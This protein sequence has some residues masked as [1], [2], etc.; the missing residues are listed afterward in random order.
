MNIYIRERV[1][2]IKFWELGKVL[3]VHIALDKAL[4]YAYVEERFFRMYAIF[5]T[6]FVNTR[7]KK[8]VRTPQMEFLYRYHYN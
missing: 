5:H 6:Y 1:S 3:G 7:L 2:I 8:Y 4:D